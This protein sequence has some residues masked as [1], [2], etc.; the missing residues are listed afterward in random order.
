MKCNF[1]LS[2]K[3]LI[4]LIALNLLTSIVFSGYLYQ[5]QKK[6]IL[7]GIDRQLTASAHGTRLVADPFHDVLGAPE[8]INPASYQKL[9][10]R[11]TA[12]A[13]ETG[14]K[15]LYTMVQKDGKIVFTLSSYSKEDKE[16]GKINNLFDPYDDASQGLQDA[17]KDGTVHFDEYS[18]T[19]GD[20]RS[21]FIPCTS[22]D[23][24]SYIVGADVSLGD[25]NRQL[26]KSLL[27]CLIIGSCVFI[28]GF[29]MVLAVVGSIKKVLLSFAASVNNIADG[30]LTSRV[31]YESSDELGRLSTDINRMTE[32]LREI[33]ADVRGSADNVA[34]ASS[35]LSSTAA[36]ISTGADEV[37]C[38]T[39]TIATASEEM[40]ATSNDIACNCAM[41]AESSQRSTSFAENGS[42]IVQ[43]TIAGM[44]KIAEQVKHSAKTVE[45]LGTRSEQIGQ[46]V[47]TI[48]DIA[49][50]TNL[51]ALNAAIEA[52]RA[53][54]QGRGFA[55]VADEVRAL[56]ERTTKATREIGDMIKTIQQETRSAVMAMNAGVAEVERGGESSE[57]SGAALQDILLQIHEVSLQISQIATAAEEQTSTTNE[58]TR[59]VLHVT[60][61]V[62]QTAKGA[63]ET[64][65]ASSQLALLAQQLREMMET[66]RIS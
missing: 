48:E 6:T 34:I 50:Q 9:Q 1:T 17:F 22:P 59:N 25:V 49:D 24:T 58:I 12:Y 27:A 28:A 36:E 21:V 56:A 45:N 55:V 65:A 26:H 20:F 4:P 41:A 37:A 14:T 23:G 10:D 35:Q 33:V 29:L 31:A 54:E 19:Y 42:R 16:K 2:Q 40:A 62:Q 44:A 11:L 5:T 3:V 39:G 38:Q 43:D 13:A 53:G 18:D 57:K 7:A 66:F 61:V 64:A 30:D 15:F 8:Q 46:I 60:E 47:G 51:L 32:K 52:A 63:K